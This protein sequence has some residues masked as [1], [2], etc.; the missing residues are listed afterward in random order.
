MTPD[1]SEGTAFKKNAGAYA[2]AV[3]Y[4]EFLYVE[5]NSVHLMLTNFPNQLYHCNK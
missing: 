5:Y 3:V 2:V 1:A 4:A